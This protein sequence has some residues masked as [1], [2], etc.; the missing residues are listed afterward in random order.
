MAEGRIGFEAFFLFGVDGPPSL[1]LV[2]RSMVSCATLFRFLPVLTTF[3]GVNPFSLAMDDAALKRV[4]L[5]V[6]IAQSR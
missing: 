4:D 5:L 6:D 2:T 1:P 3:G